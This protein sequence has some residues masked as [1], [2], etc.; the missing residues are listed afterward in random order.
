M[1]VGLPG[2]HSLPSSEEASNSGNASSMPAVFHPENYSCLQGS[3]TEMLCTEAASPRPS[4]EDL[5]LQGSPDSSTSPKQ[6]LSSPEAD[7]G[8]EEEE[9]KVLARKQKMRTVFS[10]AQLCALKD[11]F[12]K[13]KYLSLQQMQE[14]SSILNLSYK[15]V[16]T[17]FQNQRMKCKRWQKNQWLKTSNGLIQKG[18]APVEYP[19]IHCSYP[20]GYLVNASGS[21]SMWGSQT[22][23]NP[24]WSS[25]TWTNPTWNNQ[26]WTNPTWS[27]QAWTAQSWN[28][29]PWNAAPLHNFGEDF[30]QPY[31]QLQQNFSASDLEVNLEATR[32]SHAHF[33][34]PQAL[35][36]FLNYS[37][38]PPG[39]I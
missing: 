27:S 34:T 5:P 1:S 17:W 16:K 24:T 13:Q 23:T 15:Q 21:L 6:K 20:Q 31:V 18:S 3:A 8:P 39:E 32:E 12:Q 11:R 7:K 28:G 22:W 25:Q 35:E 38:T 10:Q 26:T 30:L 19:S 36:L 9:N 2:P 4:S 14:L 33:S 29:Q 37:V